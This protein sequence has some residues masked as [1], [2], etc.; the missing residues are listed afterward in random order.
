MADSAG[1]IKVWR[2]LKVEGHM[3]EVLKKQKVCNH[4]RS[5]FKKRTRNYEKTFDLSEANKALILLN[6][7]P[8][9]SKTWTELNAAKVY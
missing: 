2:D 5:T 3:E 4:V 6:L 8:R 1:T 7:C 9:Y